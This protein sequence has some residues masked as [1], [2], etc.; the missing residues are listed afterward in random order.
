M[1]CEL[2]QG[3]PLTKSIPLKIEP[4]FIAARNLAYENTRGFG[5]FNLREIYSVY[6]VLI[7]SGKVRC[8]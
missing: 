5:Q 2:L 8:G 3:A 6:S 1:R 4:R 7:Q